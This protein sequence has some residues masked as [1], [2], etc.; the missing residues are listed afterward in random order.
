[1]RRRGSRRWVFDPKVNRAVGAKACCDVINRGVAVYG[2]NVFVGV[3]DGRLVAVDRQTGLRVWE[4]LTVD[5]TLSYTIT[6]APRAANGLVYIGN[7]GAEY[8]VRGYVSAYDADTGA[9]KWRFYT[10]PGNPA[11]GPTAPPRTACCR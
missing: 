3:I 1:M 11:H 8:G 4:T 5:Q 9:L 10:V 6:G 7:G 2:D